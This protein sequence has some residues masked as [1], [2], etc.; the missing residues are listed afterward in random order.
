MEKRIVAQHIDK[1][2][3]FPVILEN[4]PMVKVRGEWTPHIN[5]NNLAREV[6]RSLIDLDGRLT[7]NQVKFIR[8][9]FEMTLQ[10]FAAR[11]AVSHPAVM[12]W[13]RAKDKPTGMN[14]GTEKDI[15]LFIAKALDGA[16]DDF[17]ELYGQL[18]TVTELKSAKLTLSAERVAA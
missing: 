5:Y 1:G 18:E 6:L 11:F 13:E 3:G 2:F 16:A 8:L 17:L 15:R 7:G 4:V 10:I 12:K 14:W 9:H